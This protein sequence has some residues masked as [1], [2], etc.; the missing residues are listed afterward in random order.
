MDTV[1]NGLHRAC[2]DAQTK[3]GI[4]ASL[5]LCFLRHLSEEEAQQTLEEA[6]P[7]LDKIIGVGLDSSERGHPPEKFERVFAQARALGLR[8]V[9][10]AGEEGPPAYIWGALDVLKAERIDHGVQAI[11]DPTLMKRLAQERIPLTVCPLSNQKLCVFSNLA[12]HNLGAML[13]QGLCVMLNSDDPAYFGGY[14]NDNFVQTF[15]ALPLTAAH[16]YQ[17]ACNS[18]EASFVPEA[19]KQVWRTQL[20]ACFKLYGA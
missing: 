9:A 20:D 15:A 3:L 17:L 18:Y 12:D 5:I 13:D 6:K 4:S 7:Y 2:V 10:H 1:I 19:Q 8:V 11:H 14:L 16:A